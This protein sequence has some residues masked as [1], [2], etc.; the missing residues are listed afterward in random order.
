MQRIKSDFF[1]LGE[2]KK[3]ELLLR[4]KKRREKRKN[5]GRG[6]HSKDFFAKVRNFG[7]YHVAADT[8]LSTEVYLLPF[9]FFEIQVV[10]FWVTLNCLRNE[11]FTNADGF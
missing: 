7:H 2:T 3:W 10:L 11:W 6:K 8:T 4:K 5:N 9:F 1:P